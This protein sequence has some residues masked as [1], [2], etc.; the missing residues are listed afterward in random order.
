MGS[1]MQNPYL[2]LKLSFGETQLKDSV[3]SD[4]ITGIKFYMS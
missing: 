1:E 2:F 3:T 4:T